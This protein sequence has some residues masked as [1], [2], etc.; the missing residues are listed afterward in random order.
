MSAAASPWKVTVPVTDA[1]L[2]DIMS[3]EL[4]MQLETEE[5]KKW[6]LC[7]VFEGIAVS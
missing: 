4:A 5:V 6:V 1:G 3:E 7:F 2:S